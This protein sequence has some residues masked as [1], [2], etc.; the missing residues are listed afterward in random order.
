MSSK[1]KERFRGQFLAADTTTFL[2]GINGVSGFL[3]TT[4]G[5]ITISYQDGSGGA[6]I[7]TVTPVQTVPVTVTLA[8]GA[9]GTI[10][11]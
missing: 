10:F 11:I 5:T 7:A 2:S 8:G 3:A 4:S 9:S 6:S 1:V